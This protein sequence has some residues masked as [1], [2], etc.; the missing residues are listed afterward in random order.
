[1][2]PKPAS[3]FH[4]FERDMKTH[5][6]RLGERLGPAW[7]SL[8]RAANRNHD[9]FLVHSMASFNFGRGWRELLLKAENT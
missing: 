9:P 4:V 7:R 1:M 2:A 6:V 5:C 3:W 8:V